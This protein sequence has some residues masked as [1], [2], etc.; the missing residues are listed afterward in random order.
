[1]K[2]EKIDIDELKKY[3]NNAKKQKKQME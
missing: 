3:E 1:M 2:I